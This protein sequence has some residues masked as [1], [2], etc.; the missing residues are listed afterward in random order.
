M[1]TDECVIAAR[2]VAP[3]SVFSPNQPRFT[4]ENSTEKSSEPS[5]PNVFL[6]TTSALSGTSR[7]ISENKPAGMKP[8]S[9]A[10]TIAAIM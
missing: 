3:T 10:T 6:A 8:I 5:Q 4:S 2:M 9:H 7:P 1:Y